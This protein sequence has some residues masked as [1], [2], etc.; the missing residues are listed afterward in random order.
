MIPSW[1]VA[2]RFQKC[3][4]PSTA[5]SD[6]LLMLETGAHLGVWNWMKT[7]QNSCGAARVPVSRRSPATTCRYEL[8]TTSSHQHTTKVRTTSV[9]LRCTSCVEQSA[10]KLSVFQITFVHNFCS[11]LTRYVGLNM[12]ICHWITCK[13]YKFVRTAWKSVQFFHVENYRMS[14]SLSIHKIKQTLHLISLWDS[15]EYVTTSWTNKQTASNSDNCAKCEVQTERTKAEAATGQTGQ[16][17]LTA[18]QWKLSFNELIGWHN[19]N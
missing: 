7:K 18:T 11:S 8:A 5:Y 6:V 3:H 19:A 15:T 16:Q 12:A 1:L 10:Y 9:Y 17:D 13:M 2:L 4:P 14:V